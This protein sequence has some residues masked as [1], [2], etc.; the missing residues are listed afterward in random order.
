[1]TDFS[2]IKKIHVEFGVHPTMGKVQMHL[3]SLYSGDLYD[4][5]ML[6]TD[7]GMTELQDN[8]CDIV[9]EQITQELI[10]PSASTNC[11]VAQHHPDLECCAA[12]R[13]V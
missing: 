10:A 7:E 4:L 11:R 9:R 6:F 13:L 8:V 1:M 12:H 3:N 2:T 5:S